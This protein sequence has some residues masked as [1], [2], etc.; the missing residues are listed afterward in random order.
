M[1]ALRRILFSFALLLAAGAGARAGAPVPVLVV[2]SYSQEYPWTLGQH[3]GFTDALKADTARGYDVRAEYLD[4]KRHRYTDGYADLM[5]GHL[6]DKYRG[7]T[8]RAIYVTDDNALAFAL[9]H[10]T[11]VFPRVP[12]F[13]SGVNDYGVK[14]GWIRPLLPGVREEGNRAQPAA[15]AHHGVRH[16]GHRRGGRR[17]RDLPRHRTRD[18]LELQD[19]TTWRR[20]SCPPTASTS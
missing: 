1:G 2:H 3:Q 12:V 17:H 9:T 18:P 10:L 4:T 5:A 16:P 19:Q 14:H 7:Y 20:T 6:R 13:F 8:P 11:R 15:D